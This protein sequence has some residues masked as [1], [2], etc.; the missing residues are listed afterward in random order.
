VQTASPGNEAEP[1]PPSILPTPVQR[2]R[3]WLHFLLIGSYPLLI[4][5][6]GAGKIPGNAP[7]LGES[8]RLLLITCTT[9]LALF[10]A[11]FFAAVWSSR[12]SWEGLLLRW[13]NG[14][15]TVPLGI[16]YSI[17]L[18]FALGILLGILVMI[19]VVSGVVSMQ[20][21]Q[22]FFVANRPDVEAVVDVS[23][24]RDNPVYFWLTITLVS[25]VVAGL[26]EEL[27]RAGFLAGMRGLWPKYFSARK[28][29]L[30]AA[31]LAAV[32]FGLGH[33]A[34]GS[35]AMCLTGLLG[36]GLGAIMIFHKSIWPA[37]IAHGMFDAASL[38]VLPWALDNLRQLHK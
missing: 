11:L 33:A 38:A 24:L 22:E 15:W 3:W 8:T 27:W 26:R 2:W 21:L 20:K 31:A 30:I 9:E 17:A 23:A 36:L 4:G 5:I 12:V 29:Q 35:V 10:G 1:S 19:L 14:F 13:R 28:G 34:Q 25:F 16:G 18:R 7:A 37:V 6:A 32:V